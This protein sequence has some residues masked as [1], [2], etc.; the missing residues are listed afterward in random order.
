MNRRRFISRSL[1]LGAGLSTPL[2]LT[3]TAFAASM[4]ADIVEM[5]A[6]SP[7]GDAADRDDP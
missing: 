1:V 7:M 4:P 5:D 3:R 2:A 6:T